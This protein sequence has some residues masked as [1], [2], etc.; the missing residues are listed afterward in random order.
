MHRR[1]FLT[2]GAAAALAPPL[3][4]PTGHS[5]PSIPP[6][7]VTGDLLM[8]ISWATYVDRPPMV[9]L[10]NGYRPPFAEEWHF[11]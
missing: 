2:A 6:T 4:T 11:D 9:K 5:W 8:V 10:W 7:A 3:P 1:A